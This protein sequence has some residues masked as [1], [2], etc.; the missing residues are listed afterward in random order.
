LARRLAVEQQHVDH[1]SCGFLAPHA[2]G[3]GAPEL[4]EAGRPVAA[5]ALLAQRE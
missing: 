1:L 3:D 4:I 5:V 2:L